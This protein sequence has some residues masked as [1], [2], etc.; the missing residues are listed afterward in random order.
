MSSE[1]YVLS[2]HPTLA[3][4][5]KASALALL[6]ICSF[7]LVLPLADERVSRSETLVLI[8]DTALTVFGL[9]VAALL[10]TLF[11]VTRIPAALALACGFL[12]MSLTTA[13][14]LLR[15]AHAAFVDLRLQFI[16]DLSLPAAII[17]FALLRRGS[18]ARVDAARVASII[19]GGI[20]ATVAIAALATWVT[21]ASGDFGVSA[22]TGATTLLWRV[23][24]TTLLCASLVVAV[25]LMWR[26]RS[27]VLGL[28]LLLT[29][30][31][32]LLDVLLRA[33]A[34][35]YGSVSWHFARSY[36]VLGTACL[37]IALLAENATLYSR[38]VRIFA[39]RDA[40][41]AQRGVA[42]DVVKTISNEL[43][44]PLCAITANADAIR[45]LLE[46]PRQ[47]LAEVRAALD[48]I[49]GDAKRASETLRGAQRML[50]GANQAPAVNEA[51]QQALATRADQRD[52]EGTAPVPGDTARQ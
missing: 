34:P 25:A 14:Q 29:L 39:G 23:L 36:G 19:A 18:A 4:R 45:Q 26:E 30:I 49:V 38:L 47:D 13:P 44:Q 46:H 6:M 1:P 40:A 52:D 12:L 24:A 20:A 9:V 5:Q 31:A 32:W 28:W 37:M 17:S 50:A 8:F 15:A 22:P 21:A 35:D 27:S 41:G 11:R 42:A 16:S 10:F 2:V 33:A 51:G 7:V 3:Q 43:H 48:D